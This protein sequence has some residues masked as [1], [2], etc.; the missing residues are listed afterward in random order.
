MSFEE[1]KAKCNSVW[2]QM[3]DFIPM[4][5]KE[6]A[7]RIKR[8]DLNL[9]QES[10]KNTWMTFG[11]NIRDLGTFREEMDKITGLRRI[12]E[13]VLFTEREVG[14]TGIKRHRRDLSSD[15]IRN[16]VTAS[17]RG[18]LKEDLESST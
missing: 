2:K 12:H 17:G 10:A 8:K 13:E 6:E 11:G 7:E 1:V 15:D 16:L 9:K 18:R 3:E 14:I 5:S 4:G